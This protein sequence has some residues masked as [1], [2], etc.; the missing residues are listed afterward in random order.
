[1]GSGTTRNL[2]SV[3]LRYSDGVSVRTARFSDMQRR[4]CWNAQ[5]IGQASCCLREPIPRLHDLL[6]DEEPIYSNLPRGPRG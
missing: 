6:S 3:L 5:K 1:M 4:Q 2:R